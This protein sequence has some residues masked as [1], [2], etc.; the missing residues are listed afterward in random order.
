[1]PGG[2]GYLPTAAGWV[3]LAVDIDLFSRKVVS[4][5]LSTCLATDLVAQ[6][7]PQANESCQPNGSQL[8]QHSDRGCH[9]T[10][11]AYQQTL[12]ILGI[13]CSMNRAGCCYENAVAERFFWSL[14]TDPPKTCC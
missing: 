6:A 10:S 3:Y 12:R 4:W 8:L 13:D 14:K 2:I 5:A 11:D 9:Y 7:L 1:M